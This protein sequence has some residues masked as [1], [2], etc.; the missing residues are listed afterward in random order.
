[1]P[2]GILTT[3]LSGLPWPRWSSIVVSPPR[4]AVRKGMT[5]LASIDR[6]ARW[7]RGRA[8]RTRPIKSS[9]MLGYLGLAARVAAT[10]RAEQ[11]G[12]VD[13]LEPWPPNR[14]A[15]SPPPGRGPA[16]AIPS[17]AAEPYWS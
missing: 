16:A 12:Y 4:A 14:V 1:M 3:K 17:N 6:P 5:R 15:H 7:R 8:P 9:K 13:V 2:G 10:E 11:V